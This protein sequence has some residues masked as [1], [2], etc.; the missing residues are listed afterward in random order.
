MVKDWR[1]NLDKAVDALLQSND[2]DISF[3]PGMIYW[4]NPSDLS[5]RHGNYPNRRRF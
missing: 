3:S 4:E 5:A 1:D 2:R